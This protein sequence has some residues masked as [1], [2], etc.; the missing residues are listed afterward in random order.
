MVGHRA[1]TRKPSADAVKPGASNIP[2]GND[3]VAD[4]K[5]ER[6]LDVIICTILSPQL[7]ETFL[8]FSFL[9]FSFL[10]FSVLFCCFSFLT[11]QTPPSS[12]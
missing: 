2:T 8:F 5:G 3:L 11:A 4:F 7:G 12:R 9:F 1:G 10:F 6:S